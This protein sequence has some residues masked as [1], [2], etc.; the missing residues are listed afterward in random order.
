MAS[1]PTPSQITTQYLTYLKALK[2]DLNIND[3]NSDFVIRG[4][5]FCGVVSGLFGDQQK[6]NNDTWVSSARPEAVI[7]KG[8]DLGLYLQPATYST[9]TGVVISGTNGTV[10]NPGDLTFI[11]VPTN[12]LY[13]NTT[14]GT[15]ANG[16]LT[17][18]VQAEVTGQAGNIVAPDVLSVVSPPSG[19]GQSASI[20]VSLADGSDIESTDSLKARIL[21]REQEPPAGGNITDYPNFAF[22]AD[23]SVR[24]A[25]VRRFDRGLGT[26]GVTITAGTTD[27]DTAVTQG[28]AIVRTPSATL[29]A[30]VQAYLN[31]HAPLT[32]C[33]MVYSPTEVAVP[34]TVNVRLA[35]GLSLTSVP[36]D[37]T[38]NP[39]GLTVQQLIAREV[40][41]AIYKLPVGGRVIPGLS[42]GY[43]VAADLESDLD[44]WLSAVKDPSTGQYL[45]HIPVLADRQVQ[46]LSSASVNLAMS[47]GQL[48]A[49]GAVTVNIGV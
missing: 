26:L 47:A 9:S 27:V 34:V 29:I 30:T 39:L 20:T 23:P 16:T 17:L 2:P 31:A 21:T 35:A 33:P 14:G 43:V 3:A 36:A 22:A 44:T 1:F 10:I 7:Q 49:P 12:T 11:Y 5:A 32:D 15:V 40:G 28:L 48:P 38:Y 4:K 19:V 18:S 37:A 24:S 6:V 8:A 25:Y 46:P 45:G 13:T 41:R 42:S